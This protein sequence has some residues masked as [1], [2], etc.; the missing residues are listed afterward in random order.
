MAAILVNLR[1]PPPQ[2]QEQ[3]LLNVLYH[4]GLL[5]DGTSASIASTSNRQRAVAVTAWASPSE[6]QNSNVSGRTLPVTSLELIRRNLHVL[7]TIGAQPSQSPMKVNFLRL[8]VELMRVVRDV[9]QPLRRELSTIAS[10]TSS[11]FATESIVSSATLRFGNKLHPAS[12]ALFILGSIFD[13]DCA[14]VS[15]ADMTML[16]AMSRDLTTIVAAASSAATS[17]ARLG[18]FKLTLATSWS[19]I[20]SLVA[21]IARRAESQSLTGVSS[22]APAAGGSEPTTT[23]DATVCTA[24]LRAL[25]DV[26]AWS[27][28]GKSLFLAQT[29]LTALSRILQ[30]L[31]W[32]PIFQATFDNTVETAAKLLWT[33]LAI[34]PPLTIEGGTST[35]F[36]TLMHGIMFLASM[37]A[38]SVDRVGLS[39]VNP[40]KASEKPPMHLFQRRIAAD[41]AEC[42]KKQQNIAATLAPSSPPSPAVSAAVATSSGASSPAEAG[43]FQWLALAVV[44][45][46]EAPN[47]LTADPEALMSRAHCT[48]FA[49][50]EDAQVRAALRPTI[51]QALVAYIRDCTCVPTSHLSDDVVFV[52]VDAIA[53]ELLQLRVSKISEVHS[54]VKTVDPVEL[55]WR[56]VQQRC[57]TNLGFFA[58]FV[59]R[60]VLRFAKDNFSRCLMIGGTAQE[61]FKG[62]QGEHVVEHCQLVYFCFGPALSW[63]AMEMLDVSL[64][65]DVLKSLTLLAPLLLVLVGSQPVWLGKAPPQSANGSTNTPAKR[66]PERERLMRLYNASFLAATALGARLDRERGLALIESTK[67]R[68]AK[69]SQYSNFLYASHVEIMLAALRSPVLCGKLPQGRLLQDWSALVLPILNGQNAAP[70]ALQAAAHD[71]MVA[72]ILSKRATGLMMVPT[73]VAMFCPVQGVTQRYPPKHVNVIRSFSK[74]V[75]SVVDH[76]EKLDVN[77]DRLMEQQVQDGAASPSP[78]SSLITPD[79]TPLSAILLIVQGLFDQIRLLLQQSASTPTQEQSQRQDLYISGLVNLLQCSNPKVTSR[80]CTSIEVLVLDYLGH[81][82]VFQERVIKFA[83]DVVQGTANDSVKKPVGEWLLRLAQEARQRRVVGQ[84]RSKL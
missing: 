18:Y 46:T 32:S 22:G 74:S 8:A 9:A 42:L 73:Y 48:S 71:C 79:L 36:P 34:R 5:I 60:V 7:F 63:I 58:A 17:S 14:F 15:D 4:H 65:S 57:E 38:K 44:C 27:N 83:S 43:F 49:V 12:I 78:D 23:S 68:V 26:D 24:A 72:P 19:T 41:F 55:L 29:Y 69:V 51:L 3:A 16:I 76:L 67:R 61:A 70:V 33:R 13:H 39:Q 59:K 1:A 84:Q 50:F 31:L 62:R 56:L 80:V 37:I 10:T 52:L 2:S 20:G 75:R 11:V 30:T 82:L 81:N 6:Q 53:L 28:S 35:T 64:V 40:P 54:S 66:N 21:A 47:G 25:S 45:P 77:D